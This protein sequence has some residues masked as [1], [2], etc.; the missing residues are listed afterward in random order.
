MSIAANRNPC[1]RAAL[2]G[3]PA[4]AEIA[5]IHN[6]ANVLVLGGGGLS[7]AE[8]LA[9]LDR[10]LAARFSDAER[11]HRRVAKLG[12]VPECFRAV[13]DVDPQTHA[14]I[15]AE[16]RRQQTSIGLIASEN[17]VSRAVREAQGCSLT[18][19]YAEGY[20]GKRWYNGCANADTVEQLAI[21][22]ARELFGAEHVNVQPHSGSSANE[23]VYLALIEPGD[24]LMAMSLAHGGHLT[25]GHE[26]NLSGRFYKIVPYG[27]SRETECIDYDELER[28]AEVNRPRMIIAG[29]SAYPRTLDFARFREIADRVDA[30][31]MVDMAHIAGL[32]AGGAHP[33][34]F[35]HADIVTTTTHKT[36]R[37][38]RG[39]MILCRERYAADIDRLVFPGTQGGPMMHTI[40]AKA[41]CFAEALQPAFRAYARQ[42]VEN[43]AA[44]AETLRRRG[45]R[46]ISGGTDNHMA[47]VDVTPLGL[48]G[49]EAADRLDAAGLVVNKNTIPFD[50]RS[51]FVTSGIRI[52]TPAATTRGMG[53]E[54]MAEIAGMICDL[55]E[56]P[57]DMVLLKH[58]RRRVRQLAAAFPV[59]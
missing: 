51:P 38:P 36:L 19:K 12:A 18:N 33:S 24:T 57:E 41:V 39:G 20:P 26:L 15:L 46:L 37:G 29:A 21:D 52:G 34:P 27:V 8:A 2:C 23:A 43:A 28:L 47:L 45:C 48:T 1:I 10:W 22:R 55:L 3:T 50:T 35:P 54:A 30:M 5:R 6:N 58:A 4:M 31:L 42:I 11:H 40:A 49:K 56:R 7:P 17:H 44:V 14:A 53:P 13:E 59:P 16:M 25:H 32:V 9:I